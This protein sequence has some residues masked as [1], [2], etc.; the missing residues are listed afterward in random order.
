[1]EIDEI[2]EEIW[3]IIFRYLLVPPTN[4]NRDTRRMAR[5]FMHRERSEIVRSN[6]YVWMMCSNHS[7]YR[8]L[9]AI[10]GRWITINARMCDEKYY[11]VPA[12]RKWKKERGVKPEGV[13]ID[14]NPGCISM[15]IPAAM[16]SLCN[17]VKPNEGGILPEGTKVV[18]LC[19][20]MDP[21]DDRWTYV[22]PIS[23]R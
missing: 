4:I 15:R 20:S 14:Y 17:L 11:M 22:T 3:M 5:S 13:V 8:R 10:S 1:M 9:F 18:V 23:S 7:L 19:N 12:M 6:Q 16:S 2:P 21:V